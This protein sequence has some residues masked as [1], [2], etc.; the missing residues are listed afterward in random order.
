MKS[1]SS[2]EARVAGYRRRYSFEGEFNTTCLERGSGT[3]I[4]QTFAIIAASV[5]PCLPRESHRSGKST[6]CQ[7]FFLFLLYTQSESP[8]HQSHLISDSDCR[9]SPHLIYL[10]SRTH[11]QRLRIASKLDDTVYAHGRL[12]T[13]SAEILRPYISRLV[14]GCS[15]RSH[16]PRSS[17]RVCS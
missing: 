9:G 1:I 11:Y 15:T 7:A 10:A 13:S 17:S 2:N 12:L 6:F 3:S 5:A 16:L 14:L 8:T 4:Q